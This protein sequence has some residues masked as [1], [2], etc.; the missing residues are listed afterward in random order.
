MRPERPDH[1]AT[2]GLPTTATLGQI[3][4][5]YR[6]L[7]RTLHP[8]TA[9]APGDTLARFTAVTTAYQVLHDPAR[10]AAYDRTRHTPPPAPPPPAAP[11]TRTAIH[12]TVLPPPA[13]DAITAS[14]PSRRDIPPPLLRAG[15]TRVSPLPHR[16]P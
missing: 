1:Y 15:P 13:P 12:V 8:D 7:V 6:A 10:R 4:H 14:T 2:L 9:A 16:G 11:R 3:A 5:A